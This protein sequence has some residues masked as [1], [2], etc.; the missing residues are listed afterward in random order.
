M[1]Y[2]RKDSYGT[3]GI[4]TYCNTIDSIDATGKAQEL[5]N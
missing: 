1:K 2:Q 5:S 3:L 4:L